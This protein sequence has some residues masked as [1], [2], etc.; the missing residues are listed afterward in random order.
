MSRRVRVGDNE[1]VIVISKRRLREISSPGVLALKFGRDI[2]LEYCSVRVIVF[3]SE[4]ADG[5]ANDRTEFVARL[6]GAV[7]TNDSHVA[8]V[9]LDNKPDRMIGPARRVLFW[10]GPVA[11]TAEVFDAR[12]RHRRTRASRS[13]TRSYRPGS[14]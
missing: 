1:R 12:K 5:L 2:E 14:A 9:Y 4:W 3:V 6:F 11:V 7:E 13:G 10:R 8:V